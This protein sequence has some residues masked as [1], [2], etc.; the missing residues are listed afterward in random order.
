MKKQLI[1]AV[2]REFGSGGHVIAKAI[3]E[4]FE[5]P[6]Y[7]RNLLHN[8][9][10][11]K[12]VDAS[13]LLQYDEAPKNRFLTRRVQGHSNSPEEN[14]AQM[15]FDYLKK[16]AAAGE[17]FV[18]IGRCA[19]TILKGNEGLL[20]MFITGDMDA[21]IKRTA[22]REG[23]SE[24][25]AEKRILAMDKQRKAYHNHYSEHRWG[26]SRYYDV[27]INSNRLGIE[28]TT[29]VLVEYIKKFTLEQSNQ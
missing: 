6:L 17:S 4:A 13:N 8:I 22:E 25:Q 1:V 16:M 26:D 19:E 10:E 18:I 15:Q 23:I 12:K 24:K 28:K 14:I 2:S 7:D 20:T 5:L 9:S 21:K 29:E 3:A 11:E 27:C